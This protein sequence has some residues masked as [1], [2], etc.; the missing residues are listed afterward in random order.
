MVEE[1][2]EKAEKVQSYRAERKKNASGWK[3]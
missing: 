3:G 2:V 1:F